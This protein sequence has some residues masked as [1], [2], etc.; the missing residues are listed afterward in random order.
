MIPKGNC[1]PG[2]PCIA[3]PLSE[4]SVDTEGSRGPMDIPRATDSGHKGRGRPLV[5]LGSEWRVRE[6]FLKALEP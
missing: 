5:R 1:H 3:Q 6:G 2:K 4:L